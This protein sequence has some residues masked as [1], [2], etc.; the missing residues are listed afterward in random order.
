MAQV[1]K[2][3]VCGFCPVH[4]QVLATVEGGR[5]VDV[6][7]Y[8]IAAPGRVPA[9]GCARLTGAVEYADNPKRLN[10]PL[11]RVGA[12][13]EGKWK[14][15]GWEEALGDIAARLRAVMEKH[16]PE[17]VAICTT[18]ESNCSYEYR[19]RFA[20]LLGTSNLVTPLQI[21]YGP[22]LQLSLMMSGWLMNFPIIG[23]ETRCFMM[24]GG[25]LS[26][27]A[28]P[29]WTGVK[30]LREHLGMKLI[31]ADPR[32]TE[33]AREADVWLPVRPNTDRR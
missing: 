17:A 18:G 1:E 25:N 6:K 14:Q 29:L 22:A 3:V 5:V 10:V 28:V 11:K 26:Q 12:R 24:L 19:E 30:L 16:G 23:I 15:V 9:P 20:S 33:A 8:K 7:P 13:G 32:K 31:V 21:C 2:R 4:C 27:N